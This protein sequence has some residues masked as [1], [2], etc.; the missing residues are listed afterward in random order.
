MTRVRAGLGVVMALASGCSSGPDGN[1]PDAA[2]ADVCAV[3]D[4]SAVRFDADATLCERLSSYG[5]FAGELARLEPGPGVLP[6]DLNTPLF[7]DYTAKYRFVWLP[8]GTAMTYH[9]TDT[10]DMPVG[11]ALLKTFAY[12]DDIRDAQGGRRLLETRLLYRTSAGWDAVTYVW[13]EEGTEAFR[14]V[15]G[16]TMPASWL[17]FDGQT[18]QNDYS[19]PNKNQ[20]KNCHEEHDDSVGPIGPKARHMNRDFVYPDGAANQLQKLAELGYLTG[21]PAD[22]ATVPRAPVW[23]D[24]ATGTLEERARGWLDVNCAHCHNPTGAARTSGLD[25][26]A[27]QQNPYEYGVCKTP[28]AA[29]DGSGGLAYSIMPGQP[30]ASILVYRLESTEPDVRMPEVGRQLVHEEGVA[31]IRSW[32]AAMPGDCGASPAQ[33]R[34][35]RLDR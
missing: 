8:P 27:A 1:E 22:L 20:C 29:G 14:S 15:A 31:L 11:T 19:V 24:E 4:G 6:Y 9:D 25:L 18:R 17:H 21:L 2:P 34:A 23:D 28:V 32:I 16:E 13:N 35:T 12:L 7:S 3:S 30:D 5:F 33:A 10:F 26:S